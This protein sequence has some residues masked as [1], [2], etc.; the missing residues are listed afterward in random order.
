M[1][2][3]IWNFI[4]FSSQKN[5]GI[6]IARFLNPIKLGKVMVSREITRDVSVMNS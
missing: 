3:K 5:Y 4:L 6:S 2:C 1:V